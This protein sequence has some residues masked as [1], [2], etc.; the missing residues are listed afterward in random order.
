MMDEFFI[1]TILDTLGA[2]IRFLFSKIFGSKNGFLYY[3]NDENSPVNV[4]I[5]TIA[6]LSIVLIVLF[7]IFKN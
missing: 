4:L 2:V 5:G 3:L 7:F 1:S 6:F